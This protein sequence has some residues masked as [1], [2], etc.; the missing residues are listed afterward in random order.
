MPP[1]CYC[2]SYGESLPESMTCGE[3]DEESSCKR[4]HVSEARCYKRLFAAM[5]CLVWDS[6]VAIV[7]CCFP[8][9]GT[10]V[11]PSMLLL[12]RHGDAPVVADLLTAV[13]WVGKIGY[14]RDVVA[15]L[16]A[17]G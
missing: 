3:W 5:H 7:M 1:S 11:N 16:I 13:A 12:C 10:V 2:S 15:V 9:A 4:L 17:R 8:A 14:A 6:G